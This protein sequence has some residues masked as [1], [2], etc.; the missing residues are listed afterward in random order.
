MMEFKPDLRVLNSQSFTAF[1]LAAKLG[2]I[3]VRYASTE[4]HNYFILYLNKFI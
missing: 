1:T 4:T 3:E 2:R